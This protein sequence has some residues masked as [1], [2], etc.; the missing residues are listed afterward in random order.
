M[1]EVIQAPHR[2]ERLTADETAELFAVI[3]EGIDRKQAEF[4][5]EEFRQ[6]QGPTEI[7]GEGVYDR[8]K[9]YNELA[10][11]EAREAHQRIVLANMP[12]VHSIANK[13]EGNNG[14]HRL[15]RQDLIQEGWAALALIVWKHDATRG[16]KLVAHARDHIMSHLS[17]TIAYHDYAVQLQTKHVE[18][19]RYLRKN[20][21]ELLRSAVDSYSG[22]RE[23]MDYLGEGHSVADGVRIFE[24][25]WRHVRSFDESFGR[26][27]GYVDYDGQPTVRRMFNDLT[28]VVASNTHQE[29]EEEVEWA[30]DNVGKV[31]QL[32][33][34][35]T[36]RERLIIGLRFGLVDG[37]PKTLDDVAAVIGVTRE[38]VRQIEVKALAQMRSVMSS[39][40]SS[41][42]NNEKVS[43]PATNGE[44]YHTAW[45]SLREEQ[46]RQHAIG[47]L[48][49]Y[50]GLVDHERPYEWDTKINYLL[51]FIGYVSP[52]KKYPFLTN[53]RDKTRGALQTD[54]LP[55][56][57][58]QIVRDYLED[59]KERIDSILHNKILESDYSERRILADI[60]EWLQAAGQ[61]LQEEKENPSE[62]RRKAIAAA[63]KLNRRK[64]AEEPVEES[65]LVYAWLAANLD[66]IHAL[67]ESER[68][69]IN[70]SWHDGRRRIHPGMVTSAIIELYGHTKDFPDVRDPKVEQKIRQHVF[71]QAR[72][73]IT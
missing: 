16:Y 5:Y 11:P 33:E 3:D 30:V 25:R 67:G 31:D 28:D 46:S 63:Y 39:E 43:V 40:D 23:M 66:K 21:P 52:D 2:Y 49:E 64:K 26:K 41:T 34:I 38:R 17:R 59:I 4:A 10:T 58:S 1:A 54:S 70:G 60:N 47:A 15:S 69:W 18:R 61:V 65:D 57:N 36:E 42:D 55:D 35:L 20:H 72:S 71:E 8:L 44:A 32:L 48:G 51:Q 56:V 73:R 68:S 27:H 22:F 29:M 6:K 37:L 9:I 14:L 24:S 7:L 13:Y 62:L 50:L 53:F 45:Q 19:S 12:F